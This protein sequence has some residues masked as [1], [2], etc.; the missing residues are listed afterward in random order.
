MVILTLIHWYKVILDLCTSE[1]RSV[2]H[3]SVAPKLT[4]NYKFVSYL[5]LVVLSFY[6]LS[7][8]GFSLEMASYAWSLQV[9]MNLNNAGGWCLV[10]GKSF[11][12]LLF[13]YRLH[14]CYEN[15][16]FV[17]SKRIIVT[18][19]WFN[20][21]FGIALESFT[22]YMTHK[23]W[24][25]FADNDSF[26]NP[27]FPIVNNWNVRYLISPVTRTF[28]ISVPH[29]EF[30]YILIWDFIMNV[31]SLFL[32]IHPLYKTLKTMDV[33]GS[34][35]ITKSMLSIAVKY[36]LLAS[37]ACSSTSFLWI[38]V[39]WI[40]PTGYWIVAFDC[41][42]NSICIMLMTPYYHDRIYYERVCCCCLNTLVP[43]Q[44]RPQEL[45]MDKDPSSNTSSDRTNN[46]TAG[47]TEATLD[48]NKPTQT[49]TVRAMQKGSQD[50][51]TIHPM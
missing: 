18:I 37:F 14:S 10:L 16:I 2:K 49:S 11:M 20:V 13:M 39:S 34:S 43:K 21:A 8:I 46:S 33:D 15:S 3:R 30:L 32:F 17:Y 25:F 38:C 22:T 40:L 9:C 7:A 50:T 4:K 12:Y 23:Y 5:T 47:I 6:T 45:R 44:L 42:F 27:C 48:T 41:V 28:L 24:L 1:R 36:T 35:I 29:K 19:G 51:L 31:L 26:P